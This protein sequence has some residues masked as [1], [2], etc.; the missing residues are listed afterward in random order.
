MSD[1]TAVS[2]SPA[3]EAA[4]FTHHAE[5]LLAEID[6]VRAIVRSSLEHA[7]RLDPD[8]IRLDKIRISVSDEEA[9]RLLH[10]PRQVPRAPGEPALIR[11]RIDRQ[12]AASR[13]AG[14]EL[15][16][17]DLCDI[18]E[19]DELSRQILVMALA[20]ELDEGVRRLFGYL[21]NDLSR[22]FATVEFLLGLL[23]PSLMGKIVNAHA[24]FRDSALVRHRLVEGLAG[25]D[26]PYFGRDVRLVH[27][28]VAR[29]IGGRELDPRL[30]MCARVTSRQPNP[31]TL[32]MDPASTKSIRES[33]SQIGAENVPTTVVL[34]GSSGTGKTEFVRQIVP[35]A[36]E[37]DVPSF[38]RPLHETEDRILALARDARCLRVPIVLD[39]ADSETDD[40]ALTPVYRQL[41]RIARTHPHGV[42][43][44]ARDEAGWFVSFLDTA[45]VHRVGFPTPNERIAIWYQAF[46]RAGA[47]NVDPD[48]LTVASRYPLAGGAIDRAAI[49]VVARVGPDKARLGDLRLEPVTEACRSQLTPRLQ[50]IA[51]RIVTTFVWDDLILPPTEMENLK[52]V[53][54]Y[55]KFKGQVFDQWGYGR[56]LPYG[57]GLSVL[58]AGPPGTGKTMAAGLI[59]S[60]LGMEVF[61]ID[62][63]RTVSKYIGETE[64]NLGRIFDEA[65]KSQSILLFDEADSLFAK[66]TEV[67]SSVDRYANLEVNFLLQR[68]EDFEGV[69]ILTTN[70]EGSIDEAFRRRIRYRIHFPAPDLATRAQLWQKMVPKEARVDE[71]LDFEQLAKDYE[72]SG[73]YIK[74]AAVR[75][76]FF[77][78][79]K[80]DGLR[81]KYF[82]KAAR[83]EI[84]KLGRVV[85]VGDQ[86]EEGA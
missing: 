2:A 58:F 18:F 16:L 5:H 72:L 21:W 67:K 68:M 76:A 52:E 86:H 30:S 39:L 23:Q 56:I 85:R 49:A 61:R 6:W 17:A 1:R 4:A 43:V 53:I 15:P 63:S 19:L 80:G 73:G 81:M 46:A 26:S 35:S 33:L 41:A 8:G 24:F 60:E 65:A 77:A 48:I 74:N 84:L 71:R 10:T 11:D 13:A 75:A 78:I 57:R 37:V 32:V 42:V 82:R 83:L 55:A 51:Q 47:V 12:I 3:A 34:I 28:I 7:G 44:T 66:R 36:I 22:R 50:G 9:F 38:V 40:P 62:L 64:K 69:T 20:A 79:Q 54:G 70:F 45:V 14:V 29:A 27:S 25:G 59:G 31:V